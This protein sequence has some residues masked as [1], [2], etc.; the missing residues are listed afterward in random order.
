LIKFHIIIIFINCLK[1]NQEN[2][3]LKK[4]FTYLFLIVFTTFS[5]V[6]AYSSSFNTPKINGLMFD[7]G[8]GGSGA[9][10]AVGYRWWHFSGALGL[11]GFANDIPNYAK[12]PPVGVVISQNQPLPSGYES[13]SYTAIDVFLDA[14]F[15]ID[16]YPYSA[17]AQ[18]GFFTSQDTILAKNLETGSRYRYATSS[19]AG[20]SFG[21][22]LEYIYSKNLT[23]GAGYH[24]RRGIFARVMYTWM[25]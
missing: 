11:S 22:G 19:D 10:V 15:H 21:G 5:T 1:L 12:V 8:Y 23:F 9:S 16:F 4:I 20:M 2:K 14:G 25:K 7:L 18:I 13:Q 17:F 3:M 6:P 24:T